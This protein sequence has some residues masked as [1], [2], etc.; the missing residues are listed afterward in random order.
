VLPRYAPAPANAAAV[1]A[2]GAAAA[3]EMQLP[4]MRITPPPGALEAHPFAAAAL[5]LAPLGALADKIKHPTARFAGLDK[6]TGRIIAFDVA[7]DETVQFGTLQITPRACYTR[8]P[9]EAPLTLG[10]A[11]V[12]E[13]TTT[14]EF[15]RIFSGW[16]FAA[17]PGLHGVEHPVYDVWVTDCTGGRE[18]IRDAVATPEP[19]PAAQ[20]PRPRQQAR[21]VTP[22]AGVAPPIAPGLAPAPAVQ[23]RS[24]VTA[25]PV[26]T[27]P[28][29]S[30]PAPIQAP[31]SPAPQAPPAPAAPSRWPVASA[32]DRCPG[33][34]QCGPSATATSHRRDRYPATANRCD[35]RRRRHMQS[36]NGMAPKHLTRRE[37]RRVPHGRR[38]MRSTTP[39][40]R[41]SGTT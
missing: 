38:A 1:E 22:P 24:P 27:T 39:T 6:I 37:H 36:P 41:H 5:C 2:E 9:T 40:T 23:P 28:T 19:D 29:T 7:I 16:M 14:K 17:S 33:P 11:E 4:V 20:Q 12:D 31:A 35:R 8:P 26:T 15:K 34:Q 25:T 18:I 13:V 30:T 3:A 32:T 10:F 21:P